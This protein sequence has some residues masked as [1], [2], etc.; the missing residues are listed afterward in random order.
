MCEDLPL[1][2]PHNDFVQVAN[3][4]ITASRF[5]PSNLFAFCP[6]RTAHQEKERVINKSSTSTSQA[7]NEKGIDCDCSVCACVINSRIASFHPCIDQ[8]TT[9]GCCLQVF[10]V[11]SAAYHISLADRYRNG[12]IHLEVRNG[13][14]SCRSVRK[15]HTKVNQCTT[16]SSNSRGAIAPVLL[17]LSVPASVDCGSFTLL[18]ASTGK[19]I[20]RTNDTKKAL[21]APND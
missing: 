11:A 15:I 2:T 4:L 17:L 10:V 21:V 3:F 6:D 13:S 14:V 12:R 9:L 16:T 7:V 18:L 8:P 20:C 1:S 5:P 19:V